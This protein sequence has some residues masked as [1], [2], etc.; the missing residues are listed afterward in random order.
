[1]QNPTLNCKPE[2][3]AVPV[4]I[5]S[6]SLDLGW[7]RMWAPKL[8]GKTVFDEM[9]DHQIPGDDIASLQFLKGSNYKP[10]VFA[11]VF[12]LVW[13]CDSPVLVYETL[14]HND[15]EQCMF[16]GHALDVFTKESYCPI[17]AGFSPWW[18]TL[19]WYLL[20]LVIALFC[21]L[22]GW[23]LQKIQKYR[24]DVSPVCCFLDCKRGGYDDRHLMAWFILISLC[25]LHC[26]LIRVAATPEDEDWGNACL[27]YGAWESHRDFCQPGPVLEQ[28]WTIVLI[29]V[30][31]CLMTALWDQGTVVRGPKPQETAGKDQKEKYTLKVAVDPVTAAAVKLKAL[32]RF[33]MHH[34][35]EERRKENS[36]LAEI[37]L[38]PLRAMKFL[39]GG[40]E[41]TEVMTTINLYPGPVPDTD[42]SEN[43]SDPEKATLYAWDAC[44]TDSQNEFWSKSFH[45][46]LETILEGL[47]E[48][49][50]DGEQMAEEELVRQMLGQPDGE[51]RAKAM[52]DFKKRQQ[53]LC[54]ERQLQEVNVGLLYDF[55]KDTMRIL[56]DQQPGWRSPIPSQPDS[57]TC[58]SRVGCVQAHHVLGFLLFLIAGILASTLAPQGDAYA[59]FD[60]GVH[61]AD[62][63]QVRCQETEASFDLNPW[64][65]LGEKQWMQRRTFN[66]GLSVFQTNR[67]P[68]FLGLCFG[69]KCV[70]FGLIGSFFAITVKKTV[71]GVEQA[72]HPMK[73]MNMLLLF[74]TQQGYVSTGH[75]HVWKLARDSLLFNDVKFILHRFENVVIAFLGITMWLVTDSTFQIVIRN[76]PPNPLG[77]FYAIIL[78]GGTVACVAQALSCHMAQEEHIVSLTRLKESMMLR[79]GRHVEHQRDLLDM[80][81]ARLKSGGDYQTKLLYVPLNPAFQK[82]LLGYPVVSFGSII[83]R[84]V[85]DNLS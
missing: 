21:L 46:S 30:F 35:E 31:V 61:H 26:T 6:K 54:R 65:Y 60:N 73:I 38:R 56:D 14:K 77:G 57:G 67:A 71:M 68:A 53:K 43:T 4:V 49:G 48:V 9:R 69:L 63:L 19:A 66:F 83:G 33:Q 59:F 28:S 5:G 44:T 16:G 80:I 45:R 20:F 62:Y 15:T 72:S 42:D 58:I 40:T 7:A 22:R 50:P 12:F 3:P 85:W 29:M 74:W 82:V 13:S 81:I 41:E 75:L 51:E 24:A 17:L 47:Q 23:R 8:E 18:Y 76:N 39:G 36:R 34:T 78:T 2:A 52:D 32:V 70:I 55:C 11:P 64:C 79:L 27:R 25:F 84:I 1:M 10:L 37:M